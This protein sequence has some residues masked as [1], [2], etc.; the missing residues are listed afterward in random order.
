MLQPISDSQLLTRLL[1]QLQQ[2]LSPLD[3]AVQLI[4]ASYE[5][6]SDLKEESGTALSLLNQQ[7]H[8]LTRMFHDLTLLHTP[9]EQV[10][11]NPEPLDLGILCRSLVADMEHLAQH[12]NVRINAKP[13]IQEA[14]HLPVVGDHLLLQRMILHLVSNAMRAAGKGGQVELVVSRSRDR[15]VLTV[16]DT[17]SGYQPPAE[18]TLGNG[19][20]HQSVGI[21]LSVAQQI[22][23]LHKGTL[24]LE[25]GEDHGMR[26][27]VSLP[28]CKECVPDDRLFCASDALGGFQPLLVE[29]STVLPSEI[30]Q[31]WDLE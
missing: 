6:H 18:Y 3:G 16:R 29:L 7:I 2:Q 5:E 17:G 26:A 12:A 4:A 14:C 21:G 20:V 15:A 22:A 31:P 8:R 23:K 27:V 1:Q 25:H 30:Y 19:Q 24:V 9:P 10:F 11:L 13:Y 28:V